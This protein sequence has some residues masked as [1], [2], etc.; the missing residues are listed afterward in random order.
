M[1]RVPVNS[2]IIAEIGYNPETSELEVLYKKGKLYCYHHIEQAT[3]DQLMAAESKG[4]YLEKHIR[5]RY[6]RHEVT[7]EESTK[8]VKSKRQPWLQIRFGQKWFG[9]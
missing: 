2:K 5:D 3:Y 1:K 7:Q 8:N 9:F 6:T 4:R